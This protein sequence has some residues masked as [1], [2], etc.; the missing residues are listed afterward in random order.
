M[1]YLLHPFT[2]SVIFCVGI[3]YM[4][5]YFF[6][7]NGT[8]RKISII[9][10]IILLIYAM[11]IKSV[12][13]LFSNEYIRVYFSRIIIIA[14]FCTWYLE[15]YMEYRNSSKDKLAKE[16]FMEVSG[17]FLLATTLYILYILYV[18]VFRDIILK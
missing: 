10:I 16:K 18:E 14:I 3:F 1:D 4:L 2:W 6:K 17:K 12:Q 7:V 8:L 15:D 5:E 13:Y 11:D 9:E